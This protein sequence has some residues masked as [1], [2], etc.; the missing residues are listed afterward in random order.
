VQLITR[1]TVHDRS[2]TI[3]FYLR[4]HS[5]SLRKTLKTNHSYI[6]VQKCVAF[7]GWFIQDV[8]NMAMSVEIYV[9]ITTKIL[10]TALTACPNVP[11]I[12]EVF[13]LCVT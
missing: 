13:K 6:C 4:N 9:T 2:S 7:G 10:N 11:N 1:D 12:S 8:Y 3:D 5:I